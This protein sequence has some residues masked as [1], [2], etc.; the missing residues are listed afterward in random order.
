MSC[1]LLGDA[2]HASRVALA[3]HEL[4]EDAIKY[5][6]DGE[7]NIRDRMTTSSI[8]V[9]AIRDLDFSAET[10]LAADGVRIKLAGNADARVVMPLTTLLPQLHTEATR[11]G[12]KRVI[13][14]F[15]ELEFMNPSCFKSF[16]TWIA[17]VLEASDQYQVTFLSNP[18]ML[19]QRRSLHALSC[20]AADLIS[21]EIQSY[22]DIGVSQKPGT[23]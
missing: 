7:T 23:D 1:L 20:F 14:D 22:A 2:N 6:S 15:L 11:L 16:V 8:N 4:L 5:S 19:W 10:T 9:P 17:T 21:V 12:A 3:T 18:T 13:V